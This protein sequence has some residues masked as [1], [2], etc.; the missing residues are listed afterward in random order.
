M[1][2]GQILIGSWSGSRFVGFD[3]A[4]F[5]RQSPS[6]LGSIA[7]SL[8]IAGLF[9][10]GT[11]S[12]LGLS[13]GAVFLAFSPGGFEAMAVLALALGFDPFY[14]AAHHLSRFFFLNF[15]LPASLHLLIGKDGRK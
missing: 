11:S 6:I 4:L 1:I 9:A 10:F 13:F 3:W 5:L 15:G 14:V 2:A 8:V 12:V 7:A